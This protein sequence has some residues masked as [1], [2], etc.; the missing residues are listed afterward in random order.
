[1]DGELLYTAPEFTTPAVRGRMVAL[2]DAG[3]AQAGAGRLVQLAALLVLHRRAAAHGAELVV[4]VLGDPSG[5]RLTGEPADL[6]PA[7][8]AARA[9][10][11]TRRPRTWPRRWRPWTRPT[12]RGC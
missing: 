8:L 7:W 10:P 11:R 4:R 12:A 1:M 5:R 6:L 9:A 2:V 3:P